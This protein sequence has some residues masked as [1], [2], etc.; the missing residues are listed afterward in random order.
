MKVDAH[1]TKSAPEVLATYQRLLET[2]RDFGPVV[3]EP[4]KTSIHLVSHTAFAGVAT[5]R[6]SL[7][8]TLKSLTDIRSP[9]VRKR[10]QTSAHRWHID[11][12]LTRPS[13]VDAQ[14][15]AWLRVAYQLASKPSPESC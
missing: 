12:P 9:R 8:L 2:A 10:E 1:F 13:D 14:L 11:I 5:R 6:T 15:T 3:E 4:K 7:L